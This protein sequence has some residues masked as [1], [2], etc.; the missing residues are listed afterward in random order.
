VPTPVVP[1]SGSRTRL[2]VVTVIGGAARRA[3]AAEGQP[4]LMR[5][6]AMIEVRLVKVSKKICPKGFKSYLV[7]EGYLCCGGN[8]LITHDEADAMLAGQRPG[9]VRIETVNATPNGGERAIAPPRC[10]WE[11]PFHW[12]PEERLAN[13]MV[14]LP[15]KADGTF[16]SGFG[17][18][19]W[20]N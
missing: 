18:L 10:A 12:S 11:E 6:D 8:H 9:G 7:N 16:W 20:S 15:K 14:P 13:G 4:A 17:P 19:A 2:T 1:A 3:A 5:F